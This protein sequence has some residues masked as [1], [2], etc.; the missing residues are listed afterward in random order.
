MCKELEKAITVA[1]IFDVR[2]EKVISF[3]YTVEPVNGTPTPAIALL[4]DPDLDKDK[5]EH[6]FVYCVV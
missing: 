6:S 4:Q 2:S 1:R 3:R 5:K